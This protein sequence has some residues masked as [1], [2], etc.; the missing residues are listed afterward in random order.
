MVKIGQPGTLVSLLNDGVKPIFLLGAG[1]SKQSGIKLVVEIIEE[2]AKWAYCKEN[3]IS[4]DDPRLTMSDWKKWLTQFDWYTD[5][6]SILYPIIVEHLLNPRQARKDFF[7]RIINPDVPASSGYEKLAE[8]MALGLIDTVLTAN[9]DNCLSNAKVQIR[10]PPVI[11]TIKTPDDLAQFSYTP[12]YPQLIYLHGSVEHYTDQNLNDEIQ[13]LNPKLVK[14]LI[15]LL[16]DRP[17]VVVGYRGAEPSIMNNLFLDNLGVTNN[18]HQGIYWCVLRREVEGI[19]NNTGIAP[20]LF[21]EVIEKTHSN[22]QI[23]PIDGFDELMNREIMGRLTA[24]K[25]DLRNATTYPLLPGT[26]APTFDSAVIAKD[27]IGPLEMAIIRERVKNYSERLAIKVYEDDE[28]LYQQMVRLRIAELINNKHELTRSG[29]LLFSSKTQE[30]LAKS[31]TILR[32]VGSPQWLKSITTFK[33]EIGEE[34]S[35]F[36]SNTVERLITGNIW[37][38]LNEISDALTLVNKPYRLKGDIS[39]NVYPYPTLALKEIIVNALVHRNYADEEPNIIEISASSIVI[40]S[41][42]GLVEEVKRQLTTDSIEAEIRSGR[43][44]VKGY[45]NPVIAD[46]FYGSGAMDKEGSGLSDVV[47][48]VTSNSAAVTFGPSQNETHFQ[49]TIYRRTDLV[50]EETQT[51]SPLLVNETTKLACNLFELLKLPQKIY[52]AEPLISHPKEIFEKRGQNWIPPFLISR[53][54]IWSFYDLSEWLNPLKPYVSPGTVETISI[55]EFIDLG[56]STKDFVRMLNDSFADHLF[57]IGLRVDTMRKRAYFP[58]TM[59]GLAKEITYQARFKKATRTVTKPK[60]NQQTGHI[61]YWEHKSIW[62]SFEYIGGNWYLIINPS[63]VFTIDGFKTLLK[64]ERVNIL[65]TK[66]AS[67]DYNMAVHN[68]LTFWANYISMNGDNAFLLRPNSREINEGTR[69]GPIQ[70]DIVIS[71]K[72]PTV[73]I[74]DVSITESFTEPAE[75]DDMEELENELVD[76]AKEE[77]GN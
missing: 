29:L 51:A 25:I 57:S 17:I 72:L 33:S 27:T 10:K 55:P 34:K 62:Y 60:V 3:G 43:R 14:T 5:D 2:A 58:K 52:H 28:W 42:G 45:R 4:M 21:M 15:P 7:L 26:A 61:Y 66:K 50:D 44:G 37:S 20:K 46:L 39:Q 36:D 69:L 59:D 6:Y 32:F 30:Y 11:Q 71:N 70:P 67:R 75:Q 35:D 19:S 38:Q 76:I 73:T 64:S 8:L 53:G 18:F 63:Y 74:T 22:F 13:K 24:T 16:K 40:I 68:D 47:H 48:Q 41:P 56:N 31:Y 65:S 54:R 23:I 49:V 12:R 9:F 77:Q 1:A